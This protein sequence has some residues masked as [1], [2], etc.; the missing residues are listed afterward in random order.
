MSSEFPLST[1]S[2]T[3]LVG[4]GGG[5]GGGGGEVDMW[6]DELGLKVGGVGGRRYEVWIW[7]LF[8]QKIELHK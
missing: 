6:G 4:G 3:T 5:G 8:T 2:V 7:I 1:P